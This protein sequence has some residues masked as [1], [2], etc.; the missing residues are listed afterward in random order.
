MGTRPDLSG[1]QEVC[2]HKIFD[3]TNYCV[4]R[5]SDTFAKGAGGLEVPT[6]TW[7][8]R[9]RGEWAHRDVWLVLGWR[10]GDSRTRVGY[11]SNGLT[12]FSVWFLKVLGLVFLNWGKVYEVC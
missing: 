2:T 11:Q 10:E 3:A 12:K 7:T 5:V 9:E 1:E 4:R 6:P 8:G